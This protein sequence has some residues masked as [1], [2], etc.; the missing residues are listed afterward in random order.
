MKRK[1]SKKKAWQKGVLYEKFTIIQNLSISTIVISIL[2]SL[3]DSQT[4][5]LDILKIYVQSI[6]K[7]HRKKKMNIVKK[8]NIIR[9]KKTDQEKNIEQN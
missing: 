4:L 9:C 5:S 6:Y 1:K 3:K 7:S 2:N 8:L